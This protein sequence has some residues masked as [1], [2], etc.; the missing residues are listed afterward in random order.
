MK[1]GLEGRVA[2]V[3]GGAR[4]VGRE[5]AL[6]LAAEGAAVVVNY[7]GSKAGA[8]A[9]VAEIQASGGKALALGCDIS[10]FAA[11]QQMV[12]TTVAEF[13]GLNILVNNAGLVFRKRFVDSTPEEWRRQIDVCLY[14]TLNCCHAAW[15]HLEAQPGKG[16]ILCVVGDS[17][18]VGESGLAIAAAARAGNI[19]LLK[20]LARETRNGTTANTLALGLIETAH[21]PGFI[22]ANRDKLTKLY[23]LRRLGQPAD[24]APLAVLLASEQGSWVTG[25]VVS[26]SGG[27]S[28][29]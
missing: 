26:V 15:P 13:G 25:Q 2:L 22:A 18:R 27:F 12:A 6:G 19:A 11:V 7:H 24:V 4:D 9:V 3:T 1:L 17:S 8:E 10:D 23:P 5:I 21:D 20:S 14:G 16:R 28:M 29:V